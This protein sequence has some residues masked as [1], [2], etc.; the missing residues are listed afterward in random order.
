M[1][2]GIRGQGS[3]MVSCKDNENA[4]L[5]NVEIPD[6]NAGKVTKLKHAMYQWS[7]YSKAE[8]AEDRK[9][10]L[11]KKATEIAEEKNTTMEKIMKQLILRKSQKMICYSNQDGSGEI[12]IR[13]A[14]PELLILMRM[15]WSMNSQEWNI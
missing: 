7:K 13:G 14:Y 6:T 3:A 10:F 9:T 4:L 1:Q 11:K 5:Q 2:Q 15:G 12:A 8:S